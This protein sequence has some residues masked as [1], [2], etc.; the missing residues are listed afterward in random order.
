MPVGRDTRHGVLKRKCYRFRN[1][2]SDG[3]ENTLPQYFESPSGDF[4]ETEML[5]EFHHNL[6][7]NFNSLIAS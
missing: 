1:S 6:V 7:S 4:D 2:N 5:A 3:A